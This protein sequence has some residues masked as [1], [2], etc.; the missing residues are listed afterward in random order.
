MWRLRR[1]IPRTWRRRSTMWCA[2]Y[3]DKGVNRGD[4][5]KDEDPI[6]RGALSG[7]RTTEGPETREGRMALSVSFYDELGLQEHLN[8]QNRMSGHLQ[9][10]PRSG[11]PP[12][13]Q[14][15]K[16]IAQLWEIRQIPDLQSPPT[17]VQCQKKRV[18]R[19]IHSRTD[20]IMRVDFHQWSIL[21]ILGGFCMTVLSHQ[22]LQV[23][24]PK[25]AWNYD[26]YQKLPT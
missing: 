20:A 16:D 15:H 7:T 26:C 11:R 21:V 13:R 8:L 23:A 10:L 24:G 2:L 1:R 5:K 3:G 4:G 6:L 12:S 19:V 14:L 25:V 17:S 9:G 22:D 18:P